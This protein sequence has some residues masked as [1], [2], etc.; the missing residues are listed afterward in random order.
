MAADET[1]S[2]FVAARRMKALATGIALRRALAAGGGAVV[3]TVELLT[4]TLR[5]RVCRR[6]GAARTLDDVP[7]RAALDWL[8]DKPRTRFR[9][10]YT[11]YERTQVTTLTQQL[12]AW[13]LAFGLS[14]RNVAGKLRCMA[15]ARQRAC[16]SHE[17]TPA[18]LKAR[19]D[20]G[21]SALARPSA[22]LRASE[23]VVAIRVAVLWADVAAVQSLTAWQQAAPARHGRP[24]PRNAHARK[25]VRMTVA[26]EGQPGPELAA[27]GQSVHNATP[28]GAGVAV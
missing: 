8:V 27:H 16:N 1:A 2:A 6:R 4:A 26:D 22:R 25:A 14:N 9:A 13:C 28:Q 23:A 10:V 24:V 18:V 21:V 15:A 5:A 17:A 11:A 12:G 19:Q 7:T 3:T 20:A